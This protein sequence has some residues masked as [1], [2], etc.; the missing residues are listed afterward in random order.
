MKKY[1]ILFS[2][3]HTL[4]RLTTAATD[5][6]DLAVGVCRIYKH[7]FRANRVLMI[8]RNMD[9]QGVI[10]ICLE[11]KKLYVRKGG[12]S[13]LTKRERDIFNQGREF[14]SDNR[15]IYPFSF[16]DTLG[17]IYIKRRQQKE[18]FG[19]LEKKWF[20]SLSEQVS[21]SLRIFCLQREQKKIL[22]GY[23]KV[24]T[25]FLDQ[26]TPVHSRSILRLIRLIGKKVKLSELE[27]RALE[28]AALLHDVGE[29]QIPSKILKK[30]K[31]LTRQEFNIMMKHPRKGVELIKDLS[32][33]RPV[34]PI[35]LHHHERYD[36]KGY[37]SCMKKEQIPLGARIL[38][39]IDS[40]DAMFFG[41]P[42]KKRMKLKRV[43]KELRRQSGRQFDP[44]IVEI[45]LRVLKRKDIRKHLHFSL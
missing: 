25:K 11:D 18:K 30:Q 9:A 40:F 3:F 5:V 27:T 21:L 32:I 8:C 17:V 23:I 36:G 1:N 41:R 15:L 42:Y 22:I 43:Q 4:Y 37:P 2:S 35:I 10:K 28:Y 38:A 13:I 34:I 31:P 6:R 19:E 7:T 44:K 16:I 12:V 20:L 45:F 26:Y 33:L 14:I 39:V 24:L 29:I